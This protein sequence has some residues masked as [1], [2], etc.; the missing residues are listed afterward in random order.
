MDETNKKQIRATLYNVRPIVDALKAHALRVTKAYRYREGH[1]PFYGLCRILLY[2]VA[3]TAT[4]AGLEQED[5]LPDPT[6]LGAIFDAIDIN[7]T[8]RR[9]G[10]QGRHTKIGYWDVTLTVAMDELEKE[11]IV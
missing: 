9:Y 7:E 10:Q 6:A 3:Y 8:V 4:K 1:L 2:E 5:F 11:M